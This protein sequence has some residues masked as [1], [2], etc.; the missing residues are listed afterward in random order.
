MACLAALSILSACGG[1][2][3]DGDGFS[4]G[5]YVEGQPVGG[6]I[7]AGRAQGIAIS[8][9]QSIELEAS[10]PVVWTLQV[11]NTYFEG[12][13]SSFYYQGVTI[14]GTPLSRSTLAVDT[15]ASSYLPAPV[16]IRLFAVSTYDSAVVATLDVLITN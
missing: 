10:E 5:V 11:G 8:A 2:G 3:G 4:V 12:F 14:T 7:Y 6:G 1:G 15:Y 13:N 16:A 9:G